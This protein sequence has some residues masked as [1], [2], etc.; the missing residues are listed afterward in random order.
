MR[1]TVDLLELP[2]GDGFLFI[3]RVVAFRA[4]EWMETEKCYSSAHPIIAAHFANGPKLVPGVILAEQ[5]CQTALLLGIRSGMFG[6]KSPPLLGEVKARFPQPALADCV[7]T[8]RVTV[9]TCIRR[10][11]S[12]QGRAFR[13]NE[14]VCK[15]SGLIIFPGAPPPRLLCAERD[16]R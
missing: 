13:A 2:Y 3:D 10:A 14:L 15:L 9:D 6:G 8:S 7:I 4:S 16:E 5:I 11:V 12:F 1:D